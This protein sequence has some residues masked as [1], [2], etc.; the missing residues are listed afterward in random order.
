VKGIIVK[1]NTLVLEESIP[2]PTISCQSIKVK[3]CEMLYEEQLLYWNAPEE[4][5]NE[6]CFNKN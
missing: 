6:L 5:N 2:Q 1:S 4:I 3:N